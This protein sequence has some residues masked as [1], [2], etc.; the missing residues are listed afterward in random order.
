M[1]QHPIPQNVTGFEFK[2]IGDMTLKQFAYFAGSCVFAYLTYILPLHF[3]IRWPI[4]VTFVVVGVSLAFVPL[5]GRPMDRMI[6]N[7]IKAL[8]ANNQYVY[9]EERSLTSKAAAA[10]P[11]MPTPVPE[12]I[13]TPTTGAQPAPPP[14]V[15]P[16]APISN[17]DLLQGPIPTINTTEPLKSSEPVQTEIKKEVQTTLPEA[18]IEQQ[19]TS[20]A[21]VPPSIIPN[22]ANPKTPEAPKDTVS[23]TFSTGASL[24]GLTH[25]APNIISGAV[26]DEKGDVLPGVIVEVK[27]KEGIS[28]RAFKA[29]KLGQFASATPLE[30][31]TY[32]VETEDPLNRFEFEPITLALTGSVM[33][34]MEIRPKDSRAELRKSLFSTPVAST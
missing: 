15:N 23:P 32:I 10:A 7:F 28:V 1:D 14:P 13:P 18:P 6:F 29:N 31:G 3:L 12:P 19:Q 9:A 5:G 26:K 27:D 16:P 25:D 33:Q 4:I 30:N 2:L 11:N 17:I 21:E 24:S 22:L 20:E 8:F 34:G